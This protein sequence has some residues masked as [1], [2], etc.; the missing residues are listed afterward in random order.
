MPPSNAL[1]IASASLVAPKK[2]PFLWAY[3]MIKLSLLKELLT[4]LTLPFS[5]DWPWARKYH[6]ILEYSRGKWPTISSLFNSVTENLLN[7]LSNSFW[8]AYEWK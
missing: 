4:G 3:I 8:R 5:I 6:A 1:I 2:E 7:W